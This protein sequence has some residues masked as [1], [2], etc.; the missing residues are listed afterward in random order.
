MQHLSDPALCACSTN[1][2]PWCGPAGGQGYVRGRKLGCPFNDLVAQPGTSSV[3]VHVLRD[4]G[5]GYIRGCSLSDSKV[6]CSAPT[7]VRRE[8]DR[9]PVSTQWLYAPACARSLWLVRL[10][11]YRALVSPGY[12]VWSNPL[13]NIDEMRRLCRI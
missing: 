6:D 2:Y 5:Y 11:A 3:I 10:I 1:S 9:R 13:Y 4:V 12:I 8:S 7:E